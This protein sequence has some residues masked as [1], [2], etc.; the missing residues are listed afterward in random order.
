MNDPEILGR[1]T[2]SLSCTLTPDEIRER[3]ERAATIQH[4][5]DVLESRRQAS[6][7]ALKL[8]IDDA[9]MDIRRLLGEVR[10]RCTDRLVEVIDRRN[11][12]ELT[13]ETVRIDTGEVA[14][15]RPMTANERQVKLFP[16][17][18]ESSEHA[19]A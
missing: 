18:G 19:S 7:K 17:G 5:R 3:G 16:A 4:E 6:N 14:R 12:D 15:S 2:E 11:D 13:I 8:E 1:R 9:D 10:T